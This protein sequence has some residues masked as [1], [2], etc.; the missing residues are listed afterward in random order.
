MLKASYVHNNFHC[1][2]LMVFNEWRNSCLIVYKI[3]CRS[4]QNDLSNRM[5]AINQ[6]MQ[7]SK[8]N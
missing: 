2:H 1:T 8:P 4:K 5:D 3:T 7:E 6:K